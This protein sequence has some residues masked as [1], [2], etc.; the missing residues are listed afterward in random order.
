MDR[1]VDE[2]LARLRAEAEPVVRKQFVSAE[3]AINDEK[4][5]VRFV[6]TT[7]SPDRENDVIAAAGWDLDA[8]KRN[9]TVLWSHDYSQPPVAKAISVER[10]SKGLVSTAQF[11][12]KGVYAFADTVF[13]LIKGGFLNATSVGFRP[14]E[15]VR[16]GA[17]GGINFLRQELLE[18]SIV[19]VP[20]NSEALIV[21]RSK[22]I[23]T[24]PIERWAAGVLKSI[25]H[26]NTDDYVELCDDGDD[27]IEVVDDEPTFDVEPR[28]L[29]AA[30]RD[31]LRLAIHDQIN[32]AVTQA[33][34]LE[35]ARSAIREAFKDA[36]DTEVQRALAL[37]RGRVDWDPLHDGRARH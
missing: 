22:G 35:H 21:A 27:Y 26:S 2:R 20:A 34:A 31:G 28:D 24:S 16:D 25:R 36:V 1:T 5:T 8:Y 13:E 12:P 15:F 6:I 33:Q 23:D 19:P 11:P 29:M 3:K 9:P 7:E 32:D 10:T 18:Y 14:L 30:T 17:R 4:R 37:A